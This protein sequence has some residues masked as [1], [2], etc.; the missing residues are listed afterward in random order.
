MSDDFYRPGANT[1]PVP[2]PTYRNPN[3]RS[4]PMP[5]VGASFNPGWQQAPPQIID[6][7]YGPAQ[8]M[9][10]QAERSPDATAWQ[11]FNYPDPWLHRDPR[12]QSPI[13]P[14]GLRPVFPRLAPRPYDFDRI[15][16]FPRGRFERR[17]LREGVGGALARGAEIAT[18]PQR[19]AFNY[20]SDVA[21]RFSDLPIGP[22]PTG[23]A[24]SS[25]FF[26]R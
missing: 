19:A 25:G 23:H 18:A 4:V 24:R 15:R 10:L 14:G 7:P 11:K 13:G 12:V 3:D 21:R 26:G 17:P 1:R 9:V 20:A 22:R 16:P 8:R 5:Q 2:M 6:T